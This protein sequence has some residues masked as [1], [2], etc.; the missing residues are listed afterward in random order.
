MNDYCDRETRWRIR[1]QAAV[2]RRRDEAFARWAAGYGVIHHA[3][4]T[5]VRV[6]SMADWL[7][8]EQV[9]NDRRDVYRIL[10]AADRLAN[11][12]M[13]LTVHMTYARHVYIDGRDLGDDD[14]KTAPEGHTGGA[15]NIALAY[16]GFLA[17]DAIT[18]N[19]RGWLMGQGH[20][21]A[22]VDATNVLFGNMLPA[23]AERYDYSDE[24]LT[25]FVRDFYLMEP[26][27]DGTPVSPLGS[28]VNAHTAGGLIEGGYL[29][30]GE[31]L[32]VHKPLPGER[33]V[34]FLS[35]GAFEE[36]KGGDW[37]PRWWRAKDCGLVTPIMIANGR[38]IDQRTTIS[39]EG[40]VDWFR[41][42]QRLHGFDPVDIDGRDPAAYAWAIWDMEQHLIAQGQAAESGETDYPIALPYGI[43]EVPK[44]F[45]FANAGT[46]AAHNLPLGD[47]PRGRPD[48]RQQFNDCSRRLW[49]PP[50]EFREAVAVLS[51]HDRRHRP[52]EKDHPMATRDV[53]V[54]E[55]PEPHWIDPEGTDSPMRAL[56]EYFCRLL[57]SNPDLRPRVGNPDEMRSNRMVQTLDYLKHRVT[58]PEPG[59]AESVEGKVITA[60]NE[61]AILCAALAN[62]GGI[63]LV[64][65]YEAFAVKMLGALRQDIIFARHQRELGRPPKW[66]SVPVITTSHTWE[67]GK[68]ELSHQD[69]TVAEA[70]MGEMT[71]VARVV[72]PPDGNAAV[73]AL[74]SVY[75]SHGQVWV[76]VIPKRPVPNR[77]DGDQARRL[78]A[79]GV[80]AV[81][82]PDDTQILLTAIGGYQ[83]SEVLHA[84]DRLGDHGAP[85]AV[86]CLVEPCRFRTPRD[87]QE[88]G[89]VA[90]DDEVAEAFPPA[91]ESRVFVCHTRPGP[92]AGVLRRVDTGPRTTRFLGFINRGGTFDVAGMLFANRTTW[93]HVVAAAAN[94]LGREATEFLSD[95][96]WRTV[97]GRGDPSVLRKARESMTMP[98]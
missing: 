34:A 53:A 69:P 66:L 38:R 28:H 45:G 2:C 55:M 7:E 26:A 80:F 27:P 62:K 60:L 81:R 74:R 25:R 82:R 29:G 47:S 1:Q 59:V 35:D 92:M 98:G 87:E 89:A 51:N 85:A 33:L 56:D 46:N 95:E 43:A 19:T 54:P 14:F 24:G 22:G 75:G 30:F 17:A 97:R 83:L 31:L 72:Y 37:A 40:G 42:Y 16:T 20:C 73:A 70:I 57:Q 8:T 48:A 96:E 49:V 4:T 68:N 5:Q 65:S 39:M 58:A 12:A 88:A 94:V 23:H 15:L 3:D 36:Q 11:V 77:F 63:N 13:W 50:E 52:M 44:G 79:D 61:E 10:H 93:G 64:V 90:S 86:N 9:V 18:G 6:F 32:Y 76:M 41:D 67:N 84:A 78:M 21:V 71:D 91:I